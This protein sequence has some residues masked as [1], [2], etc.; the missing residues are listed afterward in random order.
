MAGLANRSRLR[1]GGGKVAAMDH[2]IRILEPGDV[3]AVVALSLRAWAPVFDSMRATLGERV[4]ERLYP[5]WRQAQEAAV[6]N[7]CDSGSLTVWVNGD[8][9]RLGFVA[10]AQQE[11]AVAV[12]DM[13]A[14]DPGAQRAGLGASLT[15]HAVDWMRARGVTLAIVETGGDPGH[16]PARKTYELAG[17]TQMPIARYFMVLYGADPGPARCLPD[18]AG[19]P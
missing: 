6:R 3:Q 16:G 14:V 5:D 9:E 1:L 13:L 19:L 4:F 15:T 11:G 17:F 2:Q 18:G 10:A 12:I 7:V 8:D